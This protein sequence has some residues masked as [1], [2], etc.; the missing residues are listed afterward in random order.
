[1]LLFYDLDTGEVTKAK[2]NEF[3][4][5]RFMRWNRDAEII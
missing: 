5:D 1:M 4:L 2:K 3:F